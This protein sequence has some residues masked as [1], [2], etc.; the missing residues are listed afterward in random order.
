MSNRVHVK[1]IV[2]LSKLVSGSFPG[3]KVP[4]FPTF[5]RHPNYFGD[6]MLWWGL[7]ILSLNNQKEIWQIILTLCSPL[8]LQWMLM[9][10]VQVMEKQLQWR[11]G[12]KVRVKII[13]MMLVVLYV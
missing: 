10:E 9:L 11:P 8:A 1:A 7:A 3:T 2:N 13:L 4:R 6:I 12:Y 5:L